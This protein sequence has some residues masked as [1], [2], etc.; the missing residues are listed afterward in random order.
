MSVINVL[1]ITAVYLDH[2][3]KPILTQR[4][5]TQLHRSMGPSQQCTQ[6][7]PYMSHNKMPFFHY[8]VPQWS[9]FII[10]IIIAIIIIII[11][12]VLNK[13]QANYECEESNL[14]P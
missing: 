5:S 10:I 2:V 9:I 11:V 4:C 13:Q 14:L 1:I 12:V 8:Y 7:L 3:A 6:L